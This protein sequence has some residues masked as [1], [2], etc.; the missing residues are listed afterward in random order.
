MSYHELLHA[1]G[2]HHMQVRYER[3]E[4]V[5]V[6][7]DK[8]QPGMWHN[9]H[10]AKGVTGRL[11]SM[12]IPYDYNSIMHYPTFAFGIDNQKTM[13]LKKEFDG[14]V[15]VSIVPSRT[16]VAAVNRMY[17]C[18]DHYLGD[19]IEGAIPYKKFHG[20]YFKQA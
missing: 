3:D 13:K 12:G 19:D 17:E 5:D 4:Y 8:V 7:K 6:F 15:G 14:E 11:A 10:K 1:L 9:F 20:M 2:F 18:W 16:D